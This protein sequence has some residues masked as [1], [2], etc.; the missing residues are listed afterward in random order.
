M[1]KKNYFWDDCSIKYNSGWCHFVDW[2]P[3][4]CVCFSQHQRGPGRESNETLSFVK[5]QIRNLS[6]ETLASHLKSSLNPIILIVK[7]LKIVSLSRDKVAMVNWFIRHSQRESSKSSSLIG[8][9]IKL[10]CVTFTNEQFH[11]HLQDSWT[12]NLIWRSIDTNIDRDCQIILWKKVTL[13]I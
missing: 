5:F 12:C 3:L 8:S 9:P 6:K 11:T 2:K 10:S 1:K 13:M 7:I 4:K